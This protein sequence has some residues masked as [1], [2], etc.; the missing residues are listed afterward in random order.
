MQENPAFATMFMGIFMAGYG[1]FSLLRGGIW[2]GLRGIRTFT[3]RGLPGLVVSAI[4]FLGGAFMAAAGFWHE[5]L[6]YTESNLQVMFYGF[7]VV[8]IVINFMSALM[9]SGD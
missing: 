3:M 5:K 8:V 6:G 7:M 4:Y 9:A 1:A 2:V